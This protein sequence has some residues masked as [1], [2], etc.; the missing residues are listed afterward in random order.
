MARH[1]VE[2]VLDV[3]ELLMMEEVVEMPT[4]SDDRTQH[5]TGVPMDFDCGL[6][7]T[8]EEVVERPYV[9][10]TPEFQELSGL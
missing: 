9:S 4:L 10:C 5:G 8:I 2:Q 1:W 6:P 7:Q 3:P